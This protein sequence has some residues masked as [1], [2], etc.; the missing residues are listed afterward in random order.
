M[1]EIFCW[2]HG[3]F[4]LSVWNLLLSDEVPLKAIKLYLAWRRMCRLFNSC[5]SHFCRNVELFSEIDFSSAV[6]AHSSWL[7]AVSSWVHFPICNLGTHLAGEGL[8]HRCFVRQQLNIYLYFEKC[9][10]LSWR[11]SPKRVFVLFC[12]HLLCCI[13]SKVLSIYEHTHSGQREVC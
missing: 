8:R 2:A 6:A 3:S 5:T 9:L 4:L 11:V 7:T 10:V 12:A 13:N 1:S